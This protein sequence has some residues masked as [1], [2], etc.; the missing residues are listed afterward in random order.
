MPREESPARMRQ[1]ARTP[2]PL[3]ASGTHAEGEA[4][5]PPP[6]LDNYV[7]LTA[8]AMAKQTV[9]KPSHRMIGKQS[10]RNSGTVG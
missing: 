9:Y 4:V 1:R 5:R 6:G 2:I 10:P 7:R 8:K 3:A